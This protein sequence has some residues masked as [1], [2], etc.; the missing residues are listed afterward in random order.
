M[1]SVADVPRHSD[2]R[3]LNCLECGLVRATLQASGVLCS[4]QRCRSRHT[5]HSRWYEKFKL[6]I[7]HS[8]SSLL[9]LLSLKQRTQAMT[10]STPPPQTPSHTPQV[11]LLTAA[12]PDHYHYH[13]HSQPAQLSILNRHTLPLPLLTLFPRQAP[14]ASTWYLHSLKSAILK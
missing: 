7:G 5:W 9:S 14:P 11:T 6:P 2:H 12:S 10:N 3:C 1:R 8:N 4:F 13:C